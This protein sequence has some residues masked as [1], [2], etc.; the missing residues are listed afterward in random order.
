M[1]GVP[2]AV[3]T[4]FMIM[5]VGVFFGYL[6]LFMHQR[7]IIVD[8]VTSSTMPAWE[9]GFGMLLMFVIVGLFVIMLA[10]ASKD[11]GI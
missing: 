7:G 3:T 6:V 11:S 2:K 10:A 1:R 9:L 4:G 8:E 5:L